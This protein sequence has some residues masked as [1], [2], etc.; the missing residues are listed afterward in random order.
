MGIVLIYS[1]TTFEY[2]SGCPD[3]ADIV[4]ALDDSA[5]IND[6]RYYLMLDFMKTFADMLNFR[7]MRLGIE[8]FADQAQVQFHLNAFDNKED[9]INA[10]SFMHTKGSTNTADALKVI[11]HNTQGHIASALLDIPVF[12]IIKSAFSKL[13]MTFLSFL[14]RQ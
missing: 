5:S 12:Y 6:Q 3:P 2:F 13:T 1:T 8:T 14:C 7:E 4:F 9:I 10:I 11:T